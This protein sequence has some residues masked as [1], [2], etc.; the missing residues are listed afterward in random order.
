MNKA[1]ILKHSLIVLCGFLAVFTLLYFLLKGQSGGDIALVMFCVI[2]LVVYT[3]SIGLVTFSWGFKEKIGLISGL[4]ISYI[5]AYILF[6]LF[7]Y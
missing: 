4:L 1:K 6:K 2:F 3:L 7:A 5:L